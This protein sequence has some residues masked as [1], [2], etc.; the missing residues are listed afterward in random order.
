MMAALVVRAVFCA[1]RLVNQFY[2]YGLG[3]GSTIPF[4]TL[5]RKNKRLQVGSVISPRRFKQARQNGRTE[6]ALQ[7]LRS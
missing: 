7:S 3:V 6:C 4:A 1:K 5:P 2:C